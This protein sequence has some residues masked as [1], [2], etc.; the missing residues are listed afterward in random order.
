MKPFDVRPEDCCSAADGLTRL[1]DLLAL[2]ERE[3]KPV[4]GRETVPLRQA[5]GRI[6]AEDQIARLQ[7]PSQD[8]SAVDGWAVAL[9][10]LNPDGETRLPIAG[11]VAAGRPLGGVARPDC[12]YRIFTGAPI[13][14]GCDTVLM[15]EHCRMEGD[16]VVLPIERRRGSNVREAGESVAIGDVPLA[17]GTRLRPQE[18]GVAA[19]LGLTELPVYQP[20]RVAILSTGDEVR[21]PGQP[22]PS[23]CLYD[24]NRY[25]LA[26]LLERMGCVVTDLGTAPDRPEAIRALFER[27]AQGQDLVISTGGVSVGEEDHVK[28][29]VATLGHIDLWRLALKPGKPLAMGTVAGVPFLGLPGNPV[30]VMVTGLL[31]ARPLITRLS[32]GTVVKPRRFSLPAG[33]SLKKRAGRREFPRARLVDTALG[34]VVELFRSDSSG[35]LTSMT[36]ADGLVDLPEIGFDIAPGDPV[37][38]LPFGELAGG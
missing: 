15:Q 6:L 28:P 30:A 23:G 7:V 3:T 26:G 5:L 13:P 27:A 38:F 25:S 31:V 37:A 1:D 11:R 33:F 34:P 29:V 22:L 17:A 21:E 35:V 36:A 2:I 12:A 4:V 14:D 32:G 10:D 8:V 18:I 20:L 16:D 24:A 9:A 19:T